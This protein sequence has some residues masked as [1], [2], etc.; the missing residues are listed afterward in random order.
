[1]MAKSHPEELPKTGSQ[2]IR[3]FNYLLFCYSQTQRFYEESFHKEKKVNRTHQLLGPVVC[4][5][6]FPPSSVPTLLTNP[7]EQILH[8]I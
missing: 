8:Y 1:M 4:S 6:S 2:A 7:E 5:P 3:I